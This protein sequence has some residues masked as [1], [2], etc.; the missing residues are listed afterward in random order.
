MAKRSRHTKRTRRKHTRRKRTRRKHAR[1]KRT[2]R[3]RFRRRRGAGL[4]SSARKAPR[5]CARAAG[6]FLNRTCRLDRL[7]FPTTREK[8]ARNMTDEVIKDAG[9]HVT[10]SARQESL[11]TAR[12][13][14]RRLEEAPGCVE[15]PA[16]ATQPVGIDGA[17]LWHPAV[18][19]AQAH[20]NRA[21]QMAKYGVATESGKKPG[22]VHR[23]TGRSLFRR[24]G[25]RRRRTKRR[26]KR[27]KR[28]RRRR[29]RRRRRQ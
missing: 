6:N 29:S 21:D 12:E 10:A 15:S 26:R 19:E 14:F 13:C 3:K 1:R 11:Q 18:R 25:G 28:R 20:I 27:R 8:L 16:P 22:L 5:A 9:G 2:R 7:A 4:L 17:Y 24:R 23:A